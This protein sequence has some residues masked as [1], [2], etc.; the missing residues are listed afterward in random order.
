M[1]CP[2]CS[3]QQA[4][5]E[6]RFCSRCGFSLNAVRE[7]VA[8]SSNSS[9]SNSALVEHGAEAQAGQLSRSQMGVRKGARMMLA[10]VA[11]ALVVGLLTAMRDDFAILLIPLVLCFIVGFARVLYGVFIAEQ[12][13]PKVNR[14]AAQPYAVPVMPGQLDPARSPELSAPKVAP[15]QSFTAQRGKTAEMAQQPPSV[16][17]NTTRLLDEETDARRV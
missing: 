13:A 10:T 6:V 4:S 15:I 7:L 2:K 1:Y 17:E 11:L 16:T 8:S 5:D 3:Q 12:R 9:S 14:E